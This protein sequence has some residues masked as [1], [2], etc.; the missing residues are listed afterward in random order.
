MEKDTKERGSE[1]DSLVLME[2]QTN[3]ENNEQVMSV[4]EHL[5]VG[6]PE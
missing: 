1:D 5:K 4:P 3:E 6:A 2:C